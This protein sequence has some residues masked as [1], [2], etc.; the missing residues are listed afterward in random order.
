[1]KHRII[2]FATILFISL[3]AMAQSSMT[4]DQ[5]LKYLVTETQKGT[6]QQ[7]MA[8][9]LLKKGVTTTQL[10]RVRKKA[11]KLREEAES[12][13]KKGNKKDKK[14]KNKEEDE[15]DLDA[16]Q[17]RSEE[18]GLDKND[19][20]F[21]GESSNDILG[22]TDEEQRQVFGRNI[23]NAK[24]LT[25]QPSANLATPA[26]YTIGPGDLITINIWGASQQTIEGEVSS[27][28][29]IVVESIGP[30]KLAGLSVERAR[31][32]LRNKLGEHYND[33]S[34]DLSLSETRSIQVQVMGEVKLPGT[35]TLSSLSTAFNALYM[36]GGISKIG[37]LRD[38]KVYR[39]G[40]NISNIDVYDYIL[41]GNSRGDIRL[42][43]NDVIVVGAYNCLVQIKGNVKRPMWYEM[44]KTETVKD[45][46]DYAGSF[47]GNA[48]TKNVRLTRKSG[49]EYSIHTIE[50]FQMSNFALADED[51][52]QVDSIRARFSNKI[53]IRG[54]AKHPG[55]YELGGKIQSVRDLLLA[56][57][58]LSEDAYEGR[59]IMHRENDDLTLRMINVDIHGIIAGTSSDIPLRKNDVLFIPSKSDMLGERIIDIKGEVIYPG[60]YPFADNT[61]I[62]DILLQAGGLTEAGSLA[63]VDIFRRIRDNKSPLASN[64]SS[65]NF[66]FSLD[67]RFAIQQDTT[68]YLQP[69]DIV[70]VR[71]SPSYE[72]QQ[73]VTAQGEVNFEG[74]YSLTNKNYRLSDLVKA[75]GGFTDV[76]YIRGAKLIRLMTQEEMEQRDQANLK[77]QIQ[78]YEDG[79]KEGKDMNMQIADSLL[80]L[81]T[82]TSN[83]F[84][85]AINLEK[86]MANPGSYDDIL[87][88]EGDI[89]SIPEKS[90]IIKISG[91]VMYPVSMT[92]EKGRNLSYYIS[93]A[94]G[95]SNNASKRKV[96]GIN[97]NGSIV[98][99]GSNSVKAIEP[100]MEIV[101]PQKSAKKKLSTTEIIGIG[102]GVAAMASV[103]VA[104]LNAL[105]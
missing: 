15:L 23:F 100:G 94:G 82:N 49:E 75:C 68:F 20:D 25:F 84:P 10:Q 39:G 89:L 69:Y 33:C 59:A 97:A 58:G 45:L 40:K 64:N 88:R 38:I 8:A 66:S 57:E 19:E 6:S 77:A 50:E 44:K 105:K 9:E 63:R 28:G 26:N 83:T 79:I 35:Y 43:D 41:N 61:S 104:L 31:T 67:E 73:N 87:L 102:S 4:D 14:N 51:M 12:T 74:Q 99:L 2:A 1:M 46:L 81:K 91:E 36:A 90:N 16:S 24:N 3:A 30:I 47:T 76:A 37:T 85:V 54:A 71:K 93:H 7:K 80:S 56:A 53:E 11:E 22:I 52:V 62:Q 18:L 103:I 72:E 92:Y 65:I 78:L 13:N 27:D 55:L 42:E 32:V 70:V 96:Y 86:A 98:K 60:Q 48:Y 34:I 5:V 95:Y 101:V 17:S 29:Y 21:V